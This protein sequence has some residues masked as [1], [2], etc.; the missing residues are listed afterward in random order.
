MCI[1][2]R[3]CFVGVGGWWERQSGLKIVIARRI[4]YT[5]VYVLILRTLAIVR[6]S[7]AGRT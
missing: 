5:A 1:F 6:P 4:C 2:T 7:D 3:E